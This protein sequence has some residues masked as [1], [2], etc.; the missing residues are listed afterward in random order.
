MPTTHPLRSDKRRLKKRADA[1]RKAEKAASA[2]PKPAAKKEQTTDMAAEEAKLDPRQYFEIRSRA[3][4]KLKQSNSPNPYPHKFQVTT[5]MGKFVKDYEDLKTGEEK[6]DTE[7]RIGGRIYG[8]V[9]C[10]RCYSSASGRS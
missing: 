1:A 3:I 2:P 5:D 6:R 7:V 10:P 9:C 8:V 4:K